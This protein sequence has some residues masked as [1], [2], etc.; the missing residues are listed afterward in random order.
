M[1][2]SGEKQRELLKKE[3]DLVDTI[4]SNQ[5]AQFK[6]NPY[7]DDASDRVVIILDVRNIT[8]RENQEYC[9]L[10]IDYAKLLTDTLRGRKC[11]AAI[12]VDSLIKD[13][14]KDSAR[15]FH[16]QL[17]ASGFRLELIRPSNNKGKQEGVDVKIGLIAQ[18][19]VLCRLCDVV[20]LITGDGDFTVLVESLQNDGARVH[21]T[22]YSK[23]LSYS[24]R[25]Q[26]DSVTILDDLT[27]VKL[28]PKTEIAEAA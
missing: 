19:F 18:K 16:N 12:A 25:D 21:V 28:Y 11:I 10:C 6:N 27:V 1:D 20:E 3:I 7:R 15:I 24:L 22:S 23:S 14:G 8:A 9:N 4:E 5:K 17:K 2:F 13:A 26:A